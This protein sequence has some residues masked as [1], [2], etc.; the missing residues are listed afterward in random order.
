M[1]KILTNFITGSLFDA[2]AEMLD[3]FK[4]KFS[5]QTKVPIS[6]N[7]LYVGATSAAM[8]K[9]LS[10]VVSKVEA[11]YII[12]SID[13]E[14]LKG[15]HTDVDL[16][17][18]LEGKYQTMLVFAVQIKPSCSMT[19]TE[20]ATL[21][22]GFNRMAS[23]LP[24]IVFM[25]NDK[26]LSLATCERSN[27]KQDWRIGEKLGKVSIL[28][29]IDCEKPHRGH[30]DIL[31]SIG[32]KEYPTF[33]E[34]YNHWKAV[35][36]SE[37]LTKNFYR[38]IS[39]WYAWVIGSGKVKFPNDLNTTEDDT[40]YN[41]ESTIRLIT[42]L[43]FVW[44]LKRKKLIPD[45][46]FDEEAIKT[47]F[48]ENFDPHSTQT[49]LYNPEESKYY[50]LIL[51]N[52]FFAM[53]NRP[54][55]DEESNN[56]ENRRFRSE[57]TYHGK[58]K[59]Y[60][61]NNLLRYR[62]EFMPG[63]A[64]KLLQIANTCVPFLNGGLFECLDN[65]DKGL[66]YDGF[67]ERKASLEQLCF[68]DYFF[69]GEEVGTNVDLSEW[70]D[71]NAK[72]HVKVRGIIDILKSYNFTVEENTP[73]D[74]EVSLDPELLGKVFENLLASYNPETNTSAR[75]QTGSFYTPREVVKYMVDESL[76]AHLKKTCSDI[77]ESVFR[78]LLDYSAEN[79][80]QSESV[81]KSIIKAI[82]NCKILDPA[83]GSGAFPMGMLQQMVHALRKLDPTNEIW[84]NFILELAITKDKKASNITN[85]DER[86]QIRIDIEE[87]FNRNV[88]D[89][90]YARKL[91]LI[92]NCIYGVDIQ[93]IATQISKLRFFISLVAE[94]NPTTDAS[95]NFGIRPLPNLETKFV[96]ANTL[97]ALNKDESLFSTDES[98]ERIKI[99]LE[100]ANHK[101]FLAKSKRSRGAIRENITSLRLQLAN[102]LA[103]IGVFTQESACNVAQWSMFEQ[104]V[105]AN[106][107]DADWMFGIKDGFDIIIGN[108]PYIRRT[109]L[110]SSDKRIYEAQFFS[111]K[112]QY[113][114]YLLFIE[115]AIKNLK[116]EGILCYINPLRFF[117]ADYGL[118]ARTFISNNSSIRQ[119][120]DVSQLNVFESAMTYPCIFITAKT[121]DNQDTLFVRPTNTAQLSRLPNEDKIYFSSQSIRNDKNKRFLIGDDRLFALIRRIENASNPFAYYFDVARGLAN[122]LVDFQGTSYTALKSKQV[123]RYQITGENLLIDTKNASIFSDQ[124]IIMP[125]TVQYLQATLKPKGVICL[126]RIYYLIK[127]NI[128][129]NDLPFLGVFNSKLINFW[130]EFNYWSTKVSGNYFDLNG[131]QI[132]SIPFPIDLMDCREFSNLV[133]ETLKY[134]DNAHQSSAID[135]FLFRYFNISDNEIQL[136]TSFMSYNGHNF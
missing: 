78:D 27:Y 104:N 92:E 57:E 16:S 101:N 118:A 17:K 71:D 10:D 44:F 105:S 113:D 22:R 69:F 82:Y 90:D 96:S 129:D 55:K 109:S 64:E 13:E 119:I 114:I 46:F 21:V 135:D 24:V 56:D 133:S 29:N 20:Q 58:N 88:N 74:Q 38:E 121:I 8:P 103:E 54:I 48:I 126:D 117:N 1:N 43:I 6:F 124:M 53:L 39:E 108:P 23:S 2:S 59:D 51:Q 83:C 72:K 130:F 7:D 100:E 65:K 47:N 32:D 4:I 66:Y 112:G 132:L 76:I 11:S 94:Q 70:Y 107:F 87:S 33:D 79:F 3:H 52:L 28:R 49:L 9:A 73:L 68:P 91:Y 125:R 18:P 131:S 120:I 41:H 110:S 85:E 61:I 102:E 86:N 67:S 50:R 93:P 99:E 106:F 128:V 116:K 123:K 34:L 63:G 75:K 19:R 81:C 111:A 35:F 5:P 136:M 25:L 80:N 115:F 84:R 37:L 45:E 42:R 31:E 134:S 36:S 60:A 62:K 26:K 95:T 97:V 89:P 14:S 127:K 98:I 77:S 15:R 30:V 12:G 40:K 122:K